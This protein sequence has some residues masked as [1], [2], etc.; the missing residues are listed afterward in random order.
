MGSMPDWAGLGADTGVLAG[1]ST[2]PEA[3]IHC[4]QRNVT[5]IDLTRGRHSDLPQPA[6]QTLM[7]FPHGAR[8][9]TLYPTSVFLGEMT[10]AVSGDT[11]F[12]ALAQ[13]AVIGN[14]DVLARAAGAR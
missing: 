2:A 13:P 12:V 5:V 3:D 4:R 7:Q 14:A 8:S 6:G 10:L 1:S 9:C 11:G